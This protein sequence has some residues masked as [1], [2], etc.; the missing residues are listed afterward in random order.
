MGPTKRELAQ[1]I[2]E[3]EPTKESKQSNKADE[4]MVKSY[5]KSRCSKNKKR[6]TGKDDQEL[7][8]EMQETQ[9]GEKWEPMKTGHSNNGDYK[10]IELRTRKNRG[11]TTM[12]TT[13]GQ[14]IETGSQ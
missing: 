4:H 6:Q 14:A 3:L 8:Q 12:D 10:P 5:P 11:R 13:R 9:A 2:S 1:G 7:P